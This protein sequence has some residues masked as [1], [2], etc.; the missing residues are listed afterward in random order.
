MCHGSYHVHTQIYDLWNDICY[1]LQA[2]EDINNG[3]MSA[4]G[5]HWRTAFQWPCSG[6]TSWVSAILP[7]VILGLI[8]GIAFAIV[9]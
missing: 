6:V 3:D 4:A 1:H 8:I 5:R 2:Q 9:S 7:L